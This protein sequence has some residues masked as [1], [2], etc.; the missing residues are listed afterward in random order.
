LKGYL[1]GEIN[2]WNVTMSTDW[3][4]HCSLKV[5]PNWK[6]LGKRLGSQMKAVAKAINEL[7]FAQIVD[8]MKSGELVVCGFTL[9]KEDIVVKREFNGDVKK[10]EAA[11]SDDGGLMIAI[12]TTCDEELFQELRSRQIVAAVQKLRK[13]AGLVVADKVD[14]FYEIVSTKPDSDSAVAA[15]YK[16]LE[17]CFRIHNDSVVLRLKQTPQPVSKK[18][19]HASVVRMETIDDDDICRELFNLYLTTPME[20]GASDSA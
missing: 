4:K 20:G 17:D 2:A 11:V 19:S 13:S 5:Q 14:I 10:Y 6:D 8:F 15:A 1:V 3:E 7:S 12:D 18:S 16:T 9:T